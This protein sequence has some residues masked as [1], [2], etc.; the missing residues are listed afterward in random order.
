MGV[1]GATWRR[2]LPRETP[3]PADVRRAVRGHDWPTVLTYLEAV[4]GQEREMR[5]TALAAS[6]AVREWMSGVVADD[7]TPST[8]LLLSAV[9]H[10]WRAY[11]AD[12]SGH[13]ARCAPSPDRGPNPKELSIA[14]QQLSALTDREPDWPE[15]WYTRYVTATVRGV[16]PA[17][18]RPLFDEVVRRAPRH[19][20]AH[21][22]YLDQ[23]VP[24][25]GGTTEEMHAF[26]YGAMTHL[27]GVSP[28][29][30]LVPLAHLESLMADGARTC[31]YLSNPL[32]A[33]QL[34]DA[35]ARS[36]LHPDYRRG[37]DW[38]WEHNMF[39]MMF[40]LTG[41]QAAAHDMFR[42]LGGR[43]TS[44]PW[45]RFRGDPRRAHRR[46]RHRSG[47]WF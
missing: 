45:G 3:L 33:R 2:L 40:S 46:A 30:V 12:G 41:E 19:V 47:I 13:C 42:A 16:A 29:G 43:F 18:S 11:D 26:A 23:L 4:T 17:E 21:C 37:P 27:P 5:L 39:A 36:V 35:A 14:E 22:T 32:V 24:Q 10:L 8:A 34:H 31:A 25:H 20:G 44:D 28:L 1:L 9:C 6:P 7:G 38:V 15:A